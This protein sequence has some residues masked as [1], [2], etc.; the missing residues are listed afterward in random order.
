MNKSNYIF[1]IF[2]SFVAFS[3][4]QNPNRLFEEVHETPQGIE[5]LVNDG[6]YRFKFYSPEIIE[7][8]FFPKGQ[9]FE[10]SSHAVVMLPNEVKTVLTQTDHVI[11][12][13]SDGLSVNIQKYP[14]QISYWY[15]GNQVISEKTGYQKT[16]HTRHCSL[17]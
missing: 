15:H 14:F 8:S 1:C 4:A 12:F 13:H 5:V 16:R 17:I 2:C 10:D 7:T 9:N 6:K 3:I 11:M